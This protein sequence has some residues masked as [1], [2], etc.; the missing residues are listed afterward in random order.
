MK[1]NVLPTTDEF[2][3]LICLNIFINLLP[4]FT[5][6]YLPKPEVPKKRLNWEEDLELRSKFIDRRVSYSYPIF[7]F[8]EI[9]FSSRRN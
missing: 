8:I 6:E 9:L 1:T 2:G 4:I 5:D 7:I 3:K